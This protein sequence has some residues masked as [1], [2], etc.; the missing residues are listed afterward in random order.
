MCFNI[1]TPHSGY[2][3]IDMCLYTLKEFNYGS[4]VATQ[5]NVPKGQIG[6]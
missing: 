4:C 6:G 1:D 5:L 3:K 2:F